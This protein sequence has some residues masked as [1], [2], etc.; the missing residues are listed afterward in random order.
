MTAA[1]P[2][3]HRA[4]GV[5]TGLRFR[6]YVDGEV[7]AEDWL[8]LGADK[9]AT[10]AAACRHAALARAASETGRDWTLEVL[11]PDYP[12]EPLCLGSRT[13]VEVEVVSV[14]DPTLN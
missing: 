13:V 6:L 14:V 12:D 5:E 11:D 4:P 1:E 10:A 2:G 3:R 7:V 8:R 9:A